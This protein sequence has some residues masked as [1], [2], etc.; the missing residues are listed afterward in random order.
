M[1]AAG[2]IAAVMLTGCQETVETES[3]EL[4]FQ[5]L[6]PASVENS[7]QKIAGKPI[8]FGDG[9]EA[10]AES[11]TGGG[12]EEGIKFGTGEEF[13]EGGMAD[14]EETLF[15]SRRRAMGDP[16]TWEK[17]APPRY[18]YIFIVF[19]R[20]GEDIYDIRSVLGLDLYEGR[21]S[22]YDTEYAAEEWSTAIWDKD[23]AEGED[24]IY[25][26]K[27]KT[28]LRGP[29]LSIV[30]Y[31]HVY[32]AMSPVPLTLKTNG[33]T[34]VD[35]D[36]VPTT[37]EGIKNITFTFTEAM[38][39]HL[40]NIYST[41]CDYEVGGKYYAELDIFQEVVS[42]DIM[43]YHVASKVDL[44]W[45][46]PEDKQTKMRVTR[47]QPKYLFKGDSYLFK[48]TENVHAMFTSSDG[49]TP[50]AIAGD[51]AGTWWLG[52]AYFYTI[53]YRTTAGG[54]FPLQVD[55][56]V[57]NTEM[58]PATTF[59]YQKI[60]TASIRDVFAPWIRGMLTFPTPPTSAPVLET[61]DLD[62]P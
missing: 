16:G 58:E 27:I 35:K 34:I 12:F 32:A 37:E 28:S 54:K 14:G 21:E 47:I 60:F 40:Q 33:T 43:L 39:P 2:M 36:D 61:I 31:C 26:C 48:P 42:E 4:T 56:D 57:K 53:S 9:F 49:Y 59:T 1:A 50:S 22:S 20:D 52:R 5:F 10:S 11:G 30:E 46:V 25:H 8:E 15:N 24:R 41:M 55:F 7:P 23:F 38:H 44:K 19:K 45:N 13:G 6:L 18:A 51:Y 62:T 3:R 17:L 29:V